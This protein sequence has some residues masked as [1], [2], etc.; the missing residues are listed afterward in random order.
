MFNF[1][2]GKFFILLIIASFLVL[3]VAF[4]KILVIESVV[5]SETNHTSLLIRSFGG[6]RY[7]FNKEELYKNAL[8]HRI[9][10]N[11]G[12]EAYL[13]FPVNQN[14][15][16]VGELCEA[17]DLR[18][19]AEINECNSSYLVQNI[20]TVDSQKQL[21]YPASFVWDSYAYYSY[22]D[23]DNE[24]S[25]RVR[26]LKQRVVRFEKKGKTVSVDNPNIYVTYFVFSRWVWGDVSKTLRILEDITRNHV[27][28]STPGME[29]ESYIKFDYD[30]DGFIFGDFIHE[31]RGL[32]LD[33]VDTGVSNYCGTLVVREEII[34]K[35]LL[36]VAVSAV[37]ADDKS[38]E[39]EWPALIG[40]FL[41][42]NYFKE[43][44]YDSANKYLEYLSWFY[45][46][47]VG[48]RN[49]LP[50]MGE[51]NI[52][53]LAFGKHMGYY[54]SSMFRVSNGNSIAICTK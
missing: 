12:R 7:D 33:G 8:R 5:Q 16:R 49:D 28:V 53:S 54:K 9:K 30:N 22:D 23:Y 29:A 39:F 2:Y 36:S 10:L 18:L 38:V 46:R 34:N 6:D 21:P 32:I 17:H 20:G 45:K 25:G 11:N 41:G 19:I 47:V 3:F 37:M 1:T 50:V 14:D 52:S 51:M 15:S 26:G 48:I 42:F 35:I 27:G 13:F 40:W 24:I 43:K 44:D 4:Y 31:R